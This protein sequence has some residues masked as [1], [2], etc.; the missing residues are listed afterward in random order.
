M[1]KIASKNVINKN[2]AISQ[3]AKI[4][5]LV[6]DLVRIMRNV[7]QHCEMNERT[8]HVQH[9]LH[10]MQFSGYPQEDRIK[11]YKKAKGKFEKIVERVNV[12]CTRGNFG[13]VNGEKRRRQRKR[14]GSMRKVD[15]KQ[16][17]L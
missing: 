15:T 6:A 4:N 17:C 10:R 3:D 5:I 14:T 12:Q 8:Q 7:S 13:S 2:S 1:K 9:F 16:S 11:V